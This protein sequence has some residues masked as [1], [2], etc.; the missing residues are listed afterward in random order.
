MTGGGRLVLGERAT[1]ARR[2]VGPSAW[3][4]LEVLAAA[5]DDDGRAVGSIRDIAAELGVSKNAAHRALRRLVE[6]GL[7]APVQTRSG[8]GCFETGAYR[9]DLPADVLHRAAAPCASASTVGQPAPRPTRA[10]RRRTAATGDQL[11]LLTP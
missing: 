9:L 7:V 11:S 2:Q 10:S 6:A 8:G 3:A 4:A 5:A 1:E